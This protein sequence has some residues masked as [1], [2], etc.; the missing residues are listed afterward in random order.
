MSDEK[1]PTVTL[2]FEDG[3]V[4]CSILN[5]FKVDGKDY[6]ALL[7]LDATGDEEEEVYICR[8]TEKENGEAE[9]ENIED[10][11][12]YDA[13]ADAFDEW[14]DSLEYDELDIEE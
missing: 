5:V 11:D 13:A 14:L 10:D 2:F 6:I 3:D 8:Y 7:P 4:E 12:E 9:I 1:F